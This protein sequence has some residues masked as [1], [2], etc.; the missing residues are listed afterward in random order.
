MEIKFEFLDFADESF[1]VLRNIFK[2]KQT[3]TIND[4]SYFNELAEL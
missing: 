2:K 3:Y 4:A 1:N